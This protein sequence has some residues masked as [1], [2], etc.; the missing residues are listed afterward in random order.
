M[1][2]NVHI[3]VAYPVSDIARIAFSMFVHIADFD[4]NITA[5]DVRRFQTLLRDNAWADEDFRNCL[6][7]LQQNY[8]TFWANYEDGVLLVDADSIAANFDQIR[9]NLDAESASRLR[10]SLA[11]FLEKLNGGTYGIRLKQGEQRARMQ[12]S[13]ELLAILDNVDEQ[14]AKPIPAASDATLVSPIVQ[15]RPKALERPAIAAL[16]PTAMISPS[17]TPVWS[18]KTKV[19][20]VSVAWETHDTK[21]YSFVA[22]PHT[23]FHYKPGQ[24]V[25]IE[26]PMGGSVLRRSYTIS[27]SPSRP[28]TLS[29]TVKKVPMGWM[30]NWLFDN[31]V[32]G[33][34]CAVSGPAGRFTCHD[35]PS[36][37]LLFL[38]AG[39]GITPPMSMLRWLADTCSNADI[40]FINNVRTPD[41][42]IFHQEL[43][44][45]STKLSDK[46][47]LVIVP[48]KVSPLRPWHGPVGGIEQNLIQ[49]Y[50]PDFAERETFVCGPPGYMAAA[51]S[52]LTNMGLPISQYH[53]ESFGGSSA[54]PAA[55]FS[56]VAAS[57]SSAPSSSPHVGKTSS[58]L[59]PGT[60]LAAI[61]PAL[62]TFKAAPSILAK[63]PALH[64]GPPTTN[65][66]VSPT[67]ARLAL[68]QYGTPP[69]AGSV[70]TA[71]VSVQGT[72]DQFVVQPGQTILDAADAA[73]ISL[74]HSCRAGVCG[75]CK[76][77]KISGH[78]E[79]A[80]QNTLSHADKD[81]GLILTCLGRPVGDVVLAP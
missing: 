72:N 10:V 18:G 42:I 74:A 73:G 57:Q 7:I 31:M 75:A 14:V 27:S 8:S 64:V 68:S 2:S 60:P 40:V 25:T 21:T 33:F 48:S 22:E 26:V 44:H 6:Q 19:R 1:N 53:E 52:L 5:Q 38:A 4:K 20:C 79:M 61:S 67:A 24:F 69:P 76:M 41:D 47:R 56:P 59:P 77:H 16:W 12:G 50:S 13:K 39:S 34:E 28:Y 35:H 80:D 43:L 32:E 55:T 63:D 54:A 51:K 71:R 46:M 49:T 17:Q 23:L 11:L 62:V 65:A 36:S 78:V 66:A 70:K 30:S 81:A 3:N 45:V 15:R 29:I 58:Q 9:L 37:K